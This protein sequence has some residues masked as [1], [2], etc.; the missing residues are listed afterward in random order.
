MRELVSVV[1]GAVIGALLAYAGF[2]V[3]IT[4][5]ALFGEPETPLEQFVLSGTGRTL[6]S[7]ALGSPTGGLALLL[8]QG[9]K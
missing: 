1:A 7:I 8:L 5:V 4:T 6:V 3:L 2:E 9:G